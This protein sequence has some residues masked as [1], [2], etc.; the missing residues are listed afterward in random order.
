ME[1]NQLIEALAAAIKPYLAKSAVLKASGTPDGTYLYSEGGL[2]GSCKN[3]PVLINA[4]VGPYGYMGKLNWVGTDVQHPHVESL[5]YIGTSGYDQSG[6]CSDCGKPTIRRCAQTSCFGRIC[7]MTDEFAYDDI[8]LR[9]NENVP[10]LAFYGNVTD[11][12]GNVIIGQGSQIDNAFLLSLGA[13]GYN[14]RRQTGVDIWT[15]NPAAN[16]GGRQFMTGFDMLINTGK[17]DSLTGMD[18]SALD[19]IIVNFGNQVVGAT[20]VPSIYGQIRGAVRAI[21]YRIT[22][23]GFDEDAAVIDIVMH[24]T[25]WDCVAEDV[26]CNY[27]LHCANWSATNRNMINDSR[28]AADMLTSI[29]NRMVIP[30]DGKDYPVTL[31]N[32][33]TVTNR[34]YG[35]DTARCSSIYVIT[36][37]LRGAPNGGTITFGQYQDFNRTGARGDALF[38]QMTGNSWVKATDGGRFAIAGTTSGGFCADM[39]ILSKTRVRMLMPQLAARIT[40]VCCVNTIGPDMYPDVTGSGGIYEKD[41]GAETS[42]ANYLYGEC[43]PTHQGDNW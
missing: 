38:R 28:E 15:G 14:L 18:C 19:S 7:Q 3:D 34:P 23:A 12:A 27:G 8:G 43:W 6:S 40:N 22:A 29:R 4:M 42:P 20:G 24:P 2:F 41:G 11:P 1:N 35:N 26:A 39:R 37:I 36:R 30:V 31:D 33:I 16:V 21:R 5:T 32:G 25:M 9:A 17:E 10:T 13:A